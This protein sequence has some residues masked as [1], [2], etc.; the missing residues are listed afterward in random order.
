MQ[1]RAEPGW[2][3][4]AATGNDYQKDRQFRKIN[5]AKDTIDVAVVRGGTQL[6]VS[7][8]DVVVGDIMLLDTGDKARACRQAP[9]AMR[10]LAC[11]VQSVEPTSMPTVDVHADPP[12]GAW[13]VSGI[14]RSQVACLMHP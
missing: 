7:N 6:V 5:S 12:A 10:L 13:V 8:L 11:P 3:L 9:A 4:L 14:P 1:R 2:H